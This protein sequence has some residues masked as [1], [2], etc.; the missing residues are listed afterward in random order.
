M[1]DSNIDITPGTGASV[2]T[3][4]NVSGDHRQV[5]V[6]GGPSADDS[7]AEVLAKDPS[8]SDEGL[9]VRDPNSTAIV[10]GLRDIRVQS[11]VDGSMSIT[12]RPDIQRV[13]NVVDGT[14]KVSD[15]VAFSARPDINRVHSIVDGTISTLGAISEVVRVNRVHN[16]VDGTIKVSDVVA[17]S[18]RP[19]INRV[20]NVVDGTISLVAA[21]TDITNTIS[22]KADD[23]TFAVYFSPASP[24]VISSPTGTQAVYFDQSNPAVNVG[25]P[26]VNDLSSTA[27]L[28][29]ILSGSFSGDYPSGYVIKSPVSSRVIKVYA[30]SLTT[31]A[32]AASVVKFGDGGAAGTTFTD[33]ALYAPSQGISGS[34]QQVTPPGYLFA[35][36]SGSTLAIKIDE[37]TSLIHYTVSY[38]LESA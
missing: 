17:F 22:I 5:T 28:P 29:Q 35:T 34:N 10:S 37:T 1:P 11:I 2:D 27:V 4:T 32:Q 25:T 38:F 23:G 3:R 6:V 8:S 15:V 33:T 13:H 9:V 26:S 30:Y 7:V 24:T 21:V 31:T 14:I 16:V 18:A 20:H 36:A 12:N 19:D